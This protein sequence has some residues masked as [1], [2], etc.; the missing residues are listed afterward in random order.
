MARLAGLHISTS[1]NQLGFNCVYIDS[2]GLLLYFPVVGSLM[3][4]MVA[5]RH[6]I[7]HV[8]GVV[9]KFMH[10]LRRSHWNAIKHVF[11]YMV[12]TK[13]IGILFGPNDTSGVVGCTD[14]DFAI[15][16]SSCKSTTGY[17]FKLGNGAILWNLKLQECTAT[18]TTEAEYVAPSDAAKEAL[19]LGRL[20]C[21]F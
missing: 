20:A 10:N 16:V 18:S 6:D 4:A 1:Q 12:G 5:T 2:R 7:A 11:R 17:C 14:S 19:W 3:Y 13:D 15:S 8:I 9:S 21:T